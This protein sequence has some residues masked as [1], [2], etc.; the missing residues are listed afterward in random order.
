MET[1]EKERQLTIRRKK[2]GMTAGNILSNRP[3]W[4]W[5]SEVRSMR[6]V[7]DVTVLEEMLEHAKKHVWYMSMV[8]EIH[9]HQNDPS[10]IQLYIIDFIYRV[11]SFGMSFDSN[12]FIHLLCALD[13]SK[14]DEEFEPKIIQDMLHNLKEHT[15]TTLEVYNEWYVEK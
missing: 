10:K 13:P 4:T 7:A 2:Q 11:L 1:I 12:C 5:V 9:D 8:K 6:L 15:Q 3:D 14:K